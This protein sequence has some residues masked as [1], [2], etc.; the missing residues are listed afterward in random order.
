MGVLSREHI[1]KYLSK[2]KNE[3]RLTITP[4]LDYDKA[5]NASSIDVRL[6]N[7]FIIMKQQSFSVLDVSEGDKLK[8]TIEKYQKKII[9]DYNT[10]FILHPNNLI[11]GSTFEYIGLPKDLMCYVIGKSSWG[12]MGLIIAT[13]TKVDPGF[14]GSITLEIINGGQIPIVLYPGIPIA[15]LVFHEA[16]GTDEYD[17]NYKYPT[18]PNFPDFSQKYEEWKYWFPQ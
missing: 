8:N 15:Q 10:R 7:E 6:G 1:K 18:G 3:D 5:I 16:T 11:I 9:I 4:L 13:A 12:R 17:G 2:T 14:K